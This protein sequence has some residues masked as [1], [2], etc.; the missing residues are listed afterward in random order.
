MKTV[1][2]LITVAI[3]ILLLAPGLLAPAQVVALTALSVLF[4]L[5][6]PKLLN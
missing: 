2:S 6:M 5:V 3:L 1:I 4:V